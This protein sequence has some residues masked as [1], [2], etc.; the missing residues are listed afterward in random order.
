MS[1]KKYI[2]IT[3]LSITIIGILMSAKVF[4]NDT[5]YT[6][7]VGEA[8]SKYG[9]DM[10]DHFSWHDLKYSYPHWL[11]DLGI[12]NIYNLFGFRGLY[13]FNMCCYI[14]IGIIFYYVNYYYN[15]RISLVSITSIIFSIMIGGYIVVRAQSVTYMLFLLEVLFIRKLLDSGKYKY[16]IYLLIISLV[17]CNV[18]VAVWPLYFILYL[19]YIAEY[20]ISKCSK[21]NNFINK[22]IEIKKEKNIKS[23]IIFMI[24]SLFTGLITPLGSIPYT[25]FIKTIMGNSTSYILEHKL[26]FGNTTITITLISVFI[27]MVFLIFKSKKKIRIIDIFM[28]LGLSVMAIN[29][30]RHFSLYILLGM[31]SLIN[32]ISKY[33]DNNKNSNLNMAIDTKIFYYIVVIE[34][35]LISIVRYSFNYKLDYVDKKKYPVDGVKYIKKNYYRDKLKIFNEYNFGSYLLFNGIDVFIDS[36]ADLYTKEFSGLGYDI[37]DDYMDISNNYDLDKLD[38]YNVDLII[39]YKD[40]NLGNNMKNNGDYSNVYEDDYFVIYD[41]KD[42]D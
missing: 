29:S 32:M 19:P 13:I 37:F 38:K 21:I 6:I 40:S 27:L 17:I 28:I 4:Q 24:L 42:K 3:I 34:L 18:H 9:V 31:I 14:I 12:F 30:E 10:I 36:R 26:G 5:F 8:I 41:K 33:L 7:K 11:Y 35:I 25:Y 16:G 1:K 22:K 23:L 20:I 2:I 15:K 39:I